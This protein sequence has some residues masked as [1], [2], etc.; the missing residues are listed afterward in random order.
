MQKLEM[1][2]RTLP[3]KSILALALLFALTAFRL[4][5]DRPRLFL[6]GDSTMANKLP[7][8]APETGWGMVLPQLVTAGIEV[9]NHAVNGRSTKSFRTLG[10][11]QKVQTALR[12]GDWVLIQFGHNDSKV[13]DTA[14]YAAPQT[15][16]RANL[17]RYIQETRA[18]G[19]NPVL[20]TPVMRRKFDAAGQFV[21]QHGEYPGVVK[22]V[23]AQ[24]KVPLLDLHARSRDLLVAEGPE[25]SKHLFMNFVGGIYP[26]FLQAKEDNTHFSPYGAALMASLVADEIRKNIPALAG[27]L[28]PSAYPDKLEYELPAVT[29]PAFRKDTFSITRYG[30]VTTGLSASVVAQNTNAIKEAISQCARAGGGTVLVPAGSWLTGPIV[31]QSNVNLHLQAGALVQ[32]SR[33]PADFPLVTTNWEGVAAIRAQAPLSGTDLENIA[34]TGPGIFDGAGEAWRP[35]KKSKLTGGQWTTLVKSGGVLDAD[36]TTWYPTERAL[37]GASAKQPGVVSAGY[38]LQNTEAIKEFLRPNMLV[39]TNCKRVLLDGVTFQNSPAWCLHPLLCEHITLRNL[40]IRNPWYAQNGDGLDLESCRNGLVEN[41]TL[42]VGDDGICIKS[43]KDEEG[44]KR[45]V[46]TE[47]II[48][49][50]CTVF[51]GHGGFVIGSEMSG[52][53]RNLFVSNCS[54]LGTDVGLRFKTARGRGGVVEKIYVSD[55][56]MSNIPGEAI[57]FDMYYMAKDPVP[58]PGEANELPMMEAKPLDAGTPQFRDFHIRNVVCRGAETGILIRGLPEMAIK[59]I[60]IE[61]AALQAN[62]GVVCVE[63]ADIQLKN[64]MLLTPAA[65][66]MQV[67]NSQNIT[68]DGLHYQP[69][70]VTQPAGRLLKISGNRTKNIRLLHAD[71][72]AVGTPVEFGSDVSAAVLSQ[73][74]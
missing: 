53:V 43:G 30:A 31:L 2:N 47:N 4:A 37:A 20:I 18:K 49:R 33:N 52:G 7:A 67:Q 54:F 38:T 35:V 36:K 13:A 42:D 44:R 29:T 8:D 28:K 14:R 68:V 46:P 48:V 40:T 27:F 70:L 5:D 15:D 6:I 72:P 12:P 73:K 61:N 56:V 45:G 24:Y 11:W 23:A 26:K 50:N 66:V 3:T 62:K 57:L 21:D 1:K 32:F 65:T 55:V 17:I 59:N 19:A 58:Q 51:H 64:I 41:C 71:A 16:Y 60:T 69:A 63:A 39:L 22:A 25:A 9:Q 74:N 34:I 10:H